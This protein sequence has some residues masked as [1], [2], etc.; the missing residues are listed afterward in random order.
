M[1][2]PYPRADDSVVDPEAEKILDTIVEIVHAIRN[3]R[4]EYKVESGKWIEAQIH[5][6][7]L[8]SAIAPYANAIQTLARVKP[9][10][11]TGEKQQSSAGDN[12][13]VLVLKE[14]EVVIPMG[15]MIDIEAE[16]IRIQKE[17]ENA[18][19]DVERL[20]DRLSNKDFLSK[21]PPSI[22][23]KEQGNLTIRKDKLDRL[24][25]QILKF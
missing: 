2:A 4:A 23:E 12:T 9:I 18:Q 22:I 3:T 24:K 13:L 19:A 8:A 15:S 5:A 11:I 25:Q 17:I 6:G 21:A 7:E 20:E 10:T 16:K 1:I 14:S